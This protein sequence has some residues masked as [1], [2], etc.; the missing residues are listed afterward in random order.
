MRNHIT[1]HKA[2]KK[3]KNVS[4]LILCG[5]Q[6]TRLASIM[7]GKPKSLAQIKSKTFL[8]ILIGDLL[9]QGFAGITLCVGHL[10][11]HIKDKYQ[12]SSGISISEENV[13]LG[14][15]GAIKNA[16]KF[17]TSEDFLVAN[18]DSIFT[19][20]DLGE[21]YDFHKKQGGLVSV[22]LTAPRVEKDFGGV[23]LSKSN[24]ITAFTEKNKL[25]DG[26][27]MNGGVYFMKKDVL[28]LMPKKSFSL[29]FD[30]FP[31]FSGGSLSG[32]VSSGEVID[33]GTPE[34]YKR[35]KAVLS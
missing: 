33:I 25:D 5:G 6:G 9:S 32:F 1:N 15:G 4:A 11:D 31:N 2:N 16:E 7:G 22:A 8:D 29:E 14:T 30:L 12:N 19:D 10:K 28:K 17:I 13:S 26:R 35:A 23:V 34:R 18:G 24:Q 3:L 21:F 20:L 27:F